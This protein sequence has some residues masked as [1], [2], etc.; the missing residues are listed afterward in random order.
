MGDASDDDHA[1][2]VIDGIHDPVVADSN[3]IVVA[4]GELHAS[5]RPRIIAEP[6][7]CGRDAV[8]QGTMEP[9]VR[10]RHRWV[11]A[12]LVPVC[13]R[14]AY[15]RTSDQGRAASRSSRAWSAA[16]LSSR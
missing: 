6:V 1:P 13:R 5:G 7:D 14:L 16:R 2:I 8:T 4:P 9:P 10:T 3:P 15:V 11:K 12:D